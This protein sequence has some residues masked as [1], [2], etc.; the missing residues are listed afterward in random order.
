LFVHQTEREESNHYRIATLLPPVMATNI[1]QPLAAIWIV[2]E[3]PL[4]SFVAPWSA[5]DP[6]AV[7]MIETNTVLTDTVLV[8][9]PRC[10][11]WPMAASLPKPS[12]ANPQLRFRCVKCRHQKRSWRVMPGMRS[13]CRG[14]RR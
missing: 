5:K 13:V 8:N 6:G 11:A 10:G 1:W 7:T 2:P 14:T 12:S 9:C 3:H 4:F